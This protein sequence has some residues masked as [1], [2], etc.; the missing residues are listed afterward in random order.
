MAF[1]HLNRAQDHLELRLLPAP[2]SP[3]EPLG[4]PHTILTETSKA[5]VN[6]FGAPRF[7]KDGRRFL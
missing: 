5:W 2:A 1:Q 6:T 7:L 3:R 4:T